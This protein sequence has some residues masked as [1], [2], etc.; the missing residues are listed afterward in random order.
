MLSLG[1]REP[2]VLLDLQQAIGLFL[3]LEGHTEMEQEEAKAEKV[4]GT[5]MVE[6]SGSL[7]PRLDSK[8][9]VVQA[10]MTFL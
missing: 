4:T 3:I 7:K 5:E 8:C 6:P 9:A 2:S 10:L 1:A